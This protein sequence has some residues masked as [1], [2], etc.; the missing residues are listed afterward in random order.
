VGYSRRYIILYE[1]CQPQEEERGVR[2]RGRR[3]SKTG[4]DGG[5]GRGSITS[6]VQIADIESEYV[7]PAFPL[8]AH[9][10]YYY[11]H[12]HYASASCSSTT[13]LPHPY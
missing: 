6:T 7:L 5:R 3:R 12:H 4:D 11:Y 9:Y 2:S 10:Y 8:S 13:A 1:R